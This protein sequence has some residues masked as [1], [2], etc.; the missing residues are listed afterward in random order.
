LLSVDRDDFLSFRFQAYLINLISD[1]TL[2]P[3]LNP[4][5]TRSKVLVFFLTSIFILFFSSLQAQQGGKGKVTGIITDA[6]S[7]NPLSFATVAIYRSPEQ[8]VEGNITDEKGE[9][10]IDI[11]FGTYYALVEFMGFEPFKSPE[12]QVTKE[13]PVYRFESLKLNPTMSNL[14]EV[15][16]EGEKA[17]MELALGQKGIQC[18]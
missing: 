10:S 5:K 8:L 11:P 9:F 13:Q 4:S 3:H 17:F 16:V 7:G 14:S 2:N 1:L 6:I 12:F 15:V 18:R